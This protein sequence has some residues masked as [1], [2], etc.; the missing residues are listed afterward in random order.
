MN[1][2]AANQS[3]PWKRRRWVPVRRLALPGWTY[4][5]NG[6][7]WVFGIQWTPAPLRSIR[8]HLG[9]HCWGWQQQPTAS[10]VRNGD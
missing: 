2:N 10:C 4:R 9:P 5:H 1:V 7:S 3:A 6:R 8:I